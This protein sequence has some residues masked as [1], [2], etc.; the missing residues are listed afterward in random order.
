MSGS[1][2]P[3][4][5]INAKIRLAARKLSSRRWLHVGVFVVLKAFTTLEKKIKFSPDIGTIVHDKNCRENRF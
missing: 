4:T 1:D 3:D 2:F 5:G